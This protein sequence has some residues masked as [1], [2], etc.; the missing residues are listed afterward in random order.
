MKK[1]ITVLST[2]ILIALVAFG[3]SNSSSE[4]NIPPKNSMSCEV[5][6]TSWKTNSLSDVT[7]SKYMVVLAATNKVEQTMVI[8]TF[9]RK[10]A[11]AGAV[12]PYKFK[13]GETK[14]E[15]VTFRTLG[16]NGMPMYD[17][18]DNTP[19]GSITITKAT[20]SYVEG[21]FVATSKN[22]AIT[23]GKFAMKLTKIW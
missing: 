13:M 19:T 17:Q 1:I 7:S 22:Y 21:T 3:N 23:K 12:L 8:I 5:N 2:I 18:D 15:G 6:G 16:E 14:T 10:K 4:I 20:K 9:D 11:V